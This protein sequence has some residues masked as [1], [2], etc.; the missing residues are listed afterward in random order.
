MV[1]FK[2]LNI[3]GAA[4]KSQRFA[5]LDGNDLFRKSCHA[6]MDAANF[7]ED[8]FASGRGTAP[9]GASFRRGGHYKLH[10]RYQAF[11]LI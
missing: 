8:A 10:L 6:L 3:L 2:R 5:C 4:R 9:L 7:R 1:S 11:L